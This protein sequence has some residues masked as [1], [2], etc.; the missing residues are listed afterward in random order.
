MDIFAEC[1]EQLRDGKQYIF[2]HPNVK[3]EFHKAPFPSQDEHTE[4]D[5]AHSAITFWRNGKP[6]SPVLML[7]DFDDINWYINEVK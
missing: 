4:R 1:I 6:A 3:G 5:S 2:G 7:Y